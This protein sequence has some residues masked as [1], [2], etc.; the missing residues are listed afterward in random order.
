MIAMVQ[1]EKWKRMRFREK[2]AFRFRRYAL[3]KKKF[4]AH[5]DLICFYMYVIERSDGISWS[6]LLNKSSCW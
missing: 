5:G 3:E 1:V 6:R 2:L 4:K